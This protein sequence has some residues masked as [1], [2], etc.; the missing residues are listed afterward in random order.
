M[1]KIWKLQGPATFVPEAAHNEKDIYSYDP[2]ATIPRLYRFSYVDTNQHCWLFDLRFLLQLLQYGSELKNPFT[3]ALVDTATTERLDCFTMK[4][5]KRSIPIVY[6]DADELTPEQIWNQKVLDVF[7]K[8]NALGYGAN[9]LWFETMT[10]RM[11]EHFYTRLF[12]LWA[13]LGLSEDAKEKIVNGHASGR[14]PLFRWNPM[15]ICG[16]GLEIKWWRKQNLM[17][18]KAFLSRAEDRE[19]QSTGALYVLT[20][21]ANTHPA[22]A[23]AF[24]WLVAA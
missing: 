5:R 8:L 16:R 15:A 3:Q 21:L 2:I 10:H 1:P 23:Q 9:L 11:H 18:M 12:D 17:L 6:L 7:L 14:S 4:L 19:N 13:N 20:A 24:G 22:C